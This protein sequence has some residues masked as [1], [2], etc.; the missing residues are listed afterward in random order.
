MKKILLNL[1]LILLITACNSNQDTTQV[2]LGENKEV[3]MSA[4]CNCDS[5]KTDTTGVL[6]LESEVFSGKCYSNYPNSSQ[7]YIEKEI[8]KGEYHG[9]VSYFDKQGNLL[10]SETYSKG[11]SMGDIENQPNCNCMD[12]EMKDENGVKKHYFNSSLYTGKCS[13]NFP[14]TDQVYLEANYKNGL[15]HGYTIYYK[16]DGQVLMMHNYENGEIINEITP[17][18]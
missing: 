10:Y 5:L 2:E 13:D 4:E 8:L 16:K 17:Q 3:D 18:R 1:S 12:I 15:L 11:E 6:I 9:K 14:D 7:K